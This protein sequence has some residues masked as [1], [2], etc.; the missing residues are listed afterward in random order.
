MSAVVKIITLELLEIEELIQLAL[1]KD[2]VVC[3]GR[4]GSGMDT[5]SE[6]EGVGK[7]T[8]YGIVTSESAADMRT[9]RAAVVV[10]GRGTPRGATGR[11]RG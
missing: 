11:E 1:E 4:L 5:V 10:R 2:K 6:V 7:A 9:R 8:T 3:S